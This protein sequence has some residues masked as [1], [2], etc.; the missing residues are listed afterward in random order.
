MARRL[1]RVVTYNFS[2]LYFKM[3][4]IFNPRSMGNWK[5]SHNKMDGIQSELGRPIL[6]SKF[7]FYTAIIHSQTHVF[8]G[9]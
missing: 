9:K 2:E 6:E 7:L 4:E 5:T 8:F 1:A 3:S